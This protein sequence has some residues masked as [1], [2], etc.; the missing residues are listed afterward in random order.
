MAKDIIGSAEIPVEDTKSVQRA[1]V[2]W[3]CQTETHCCTCRF[4]S[5]AKVNSGSDSLMHCRLTNERSM[6]TPGDSS[7]VPRLSPQKK[8]TK[9]KRGPLAGVREGHRCGDLEFELAVHCG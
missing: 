9:K 1:G 5:L 8:K 3:V 2:V 7:L 4:P 6:T